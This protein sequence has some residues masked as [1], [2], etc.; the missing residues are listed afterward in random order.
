[1][2]WCNFKLY[3]EP[4]WRILLSQGYYTDKGRTGVSNLTLN[5]DA[6]NL[7][8]GLKSSTY[9]GFNIHDMTRIGKAN[10]YLAYIASISSK[11]GMIQ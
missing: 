4:Y 9:F 5:Y 7:I 2:V 3:S 6:G 8:K 11:T 1:M 10:D